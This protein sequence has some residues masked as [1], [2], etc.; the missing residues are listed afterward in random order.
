MTKRKRNL[1]LPTAL[2]DDCG[3][4]L[5]ELTICPQNELVNHAKPQSR[6]L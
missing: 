3:G 2:K 5:Q 6:S 1:D 4:K